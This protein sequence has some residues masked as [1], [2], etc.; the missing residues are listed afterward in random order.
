M[1][2]KTFDAAAAEPRTGACATGRAA[3]PTACVTA[4]LRATAART[5]FVTA[6]EER[7]TK[8]K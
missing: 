3:V 6:L 1:L 4:R 2:D 7:T 8:S 5:A